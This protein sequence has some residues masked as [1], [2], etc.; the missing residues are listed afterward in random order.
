MSAFSDV[1]G[2]RNKMHV[3]GLSWT[4]PLK[5]TI[6]HYFS[7]TGT[8]KRSHETKTQCWRN[9]DKQLWFIRVFKGFRQVKQDGST[10]I[11]EDYGEFTGYK[12]QDVNKMLT[13]SLTWKNILRRK[14]CTSSPYLLVLINVRYTV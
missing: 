8:V 4:T 13:S 9:E 3:K 11:N 10:P 14:K 1:C 5:L 2:L 6:P 7:S 12:K